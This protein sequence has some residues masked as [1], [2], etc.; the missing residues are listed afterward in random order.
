[1]R[2]FILFLS[3][4]TILIPAPVISSERDFE[5]SNENHYALQSALYD[6]YYHTIPSNP[7][8][9]EKTPRYSDSNLTQTVGHLSPNQKFEIVNLTVN[10]HLQPVFQL[11]DET[12]ILA[13]QSIVF[14]DI[15]QEQKFQEVV[16][17]IDEGF[18]VMSSPI[19]NQAK[20][21]NK[22]PKPYTQVTVREIVKT[23]RGEFAKI[24]EGWVSIEFLS[25]EDNRINHVQKILNQK[26]N[27][28]ELAIYV[29]QLDTGF[30][31]GINQDKEMYSASIAKLPVLYY[32]QLG[33]ENEKFQLKDTFKY[34]DK[35]HEFDGAYLPEGSGTLPKSADSK[36]YTLENLIDLTAKKSDNVASNI[37]G[38][39]VTNQFDRT[40][41][42]T[43]DFITNKT[44]NMS[45]K[46]GSAEMA[47][48]VMAALYELNPSGFVLNSLSETAFDD[49]RIAK[50]VDAKVAH[51]IGDA[52]DFRHDVALIYTESPFVISIFTNHKTY[53][54]ISSIAA[55]VYKVLK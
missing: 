36:T 27:D 47:G 2:K 26:Y 8:V 35:V 29:H 25:I 46:Q 28:P 12:Y 50:V 55:D 45:E 33:L 10:D 31:A 21:L 18:T 42:Q 38:Y 17:W 40:Y 51:K 15:I 32:A 41:Y 23:P 48:L 7:N 43:L 3:A 20:K 37:L 52:Y 22:A 44:W 14:D 13:S 34:T 49:Q 19:G 16:F 5:L 11:S 6:G 54:D 39:Y 1:M 4:S 9:F 30:T 53:D 24:E